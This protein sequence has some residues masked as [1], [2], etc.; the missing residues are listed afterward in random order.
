MCSSD[1]VDAGDSPVRD[2]LYADALALRHHTDDHTEGN[3]QPEM[4]AAGGGAAHPVRDPGLPAGEWAVPVGDM[5]KRPIPRR[6]G[7]LNG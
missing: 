4:D 6:G 2:A 3:R 7:P 5:R 1:L